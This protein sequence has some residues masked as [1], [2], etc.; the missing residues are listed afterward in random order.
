MASS[1]RRARS[2]LAAIAV[3]AIKPG[4]RGNAPQSGAALGEQARPYQ[5]VFGGQ[6]REHL[7]GFSLKFVVPL[8]NNGVEC[9]GFL[10]LRQVGI[11]Q[12]EAGM[13]GSKR[14][15]NVAARA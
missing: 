1:S 12:I 15:E 5:L 10:H 9:D 2:A 14:G 8:L 11:E 4:E 3:Q 13:A 7:L 6:L